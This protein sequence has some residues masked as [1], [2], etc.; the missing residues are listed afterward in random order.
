MKA[1]RARLIGKLD[2]LSTSAQG[3]ANAI[4]IAGAEMAAELEEERDAAIAEVTRLRAA[5]TEIVRDTEY[6][7]RGQTHHADCRHPGCI[8]ARALEV[9]GGTGR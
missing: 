7:R 1:E 5:L 8:A 2:E 3:T 4:L 6:L 9:E